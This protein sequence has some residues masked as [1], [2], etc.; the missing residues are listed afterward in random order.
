MEEPLDPEA[1]AQVDIC[2]LQLPPRQR[3]EA[4]TPDRIGQKPAFSAL[5]AAAVHVPDHVEGLIDVVL[6]QVRRRERDPQAVRIIVR[7]VGGF[8][9]G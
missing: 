4:E 5:L 6:K 9:P 1:V 8:V 7:Y 3:D 2:L